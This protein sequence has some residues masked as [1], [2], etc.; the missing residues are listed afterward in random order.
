MSR[1]SFIGSLVFV[2]LIVSRSAADT[3]YFQGMLGDRRPITMTL[4]W[5]QSA[6]IGQ[7]RYSQFGPP[8]SLRRAKA[9]DDTLRLA[10]DGG[11]FHGAIDQQGRFKGKWVSADNK[12][13]LNFD[14]QQVA[15]SSMLL[16]TQPHFRVQSEYPQLSGST[17]FYQAL[18]A[19]LGDEAKKAFDATCAD[20]RESTKVPDIGLADWESQ[21]RAEIL[22]ADATLVSILFEDY[23]FTGGAHGNTNYRAANYAWI[24]QKLVELKPAD[25]IPNETDQMNVRI[26]VVAALAGKK[27]AWA[28]DAFGI[29]FEK[30]VV[31]PT[32]TGLV[33]TFAPYEVDCYA[34]G[35]FTV[36]L[37][38][39]K[40]AGMISETGPLGHVTAN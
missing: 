21:T 24:D 31:N 5:T 2:A 16:S 29:Q 17:P 37:P 39:K 8:I 33:F 18:N 25:L 30:W 19:R 27:A 36:E 15:G 11:E 38:Y 6:E 23:I 28:H 4:D 34:A 12:R 13:T 35:T 10:E 26:L 14:L 20:Y 22:H 32:R 1:Q 7:Y 40:L 3:G 9:S